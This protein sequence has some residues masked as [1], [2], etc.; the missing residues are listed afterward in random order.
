MLNA[1][2]AGRQFDH[3]NF[4]TPPQEL[5][6]VMKSGLG[7]HIKRHAYEYRQQIDKEVAR[8][9]RIRQLQARAVGLVA[10]ATTAGLVGVAILCPRS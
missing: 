7:G 5:M 10:T 6:R 2:G 1:I 9:N 8:I 4:D 3:A